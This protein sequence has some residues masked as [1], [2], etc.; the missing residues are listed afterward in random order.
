MLVP[1]YLGLCRAADLDTENRAVGALVN[2]N[3]GMAVLV[4]L[5]HGAAMIPTRTFAAKFAVMHSRSTIW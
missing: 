1:I 3:L 2:G 4:S 5:V